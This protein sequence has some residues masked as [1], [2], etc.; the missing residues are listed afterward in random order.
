MFAVFLTSLLAMHTILDVVPWAAQT[1][2]GA[3]A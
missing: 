1:R 2:G 3:L